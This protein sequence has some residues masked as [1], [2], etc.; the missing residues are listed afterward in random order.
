MPEI[1]NQLPLLDILEPILH[2]PITLKHKRVRVL[3]SFPRILPRLDDLLYKLREALLVKI[4][5]PLLR[6]PP[7]FCD[8]DVNRTDN[9]KLSIAS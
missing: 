9:S 8:A 4:V 6:P 1:P 5:Q 2:Y 7:D 3:S